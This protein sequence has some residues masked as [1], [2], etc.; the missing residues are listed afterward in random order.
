V[1]ES[2]I[3]PTEPDHARP[4]TRRRRHRVTAVAGVAVG[5]AL[6]VGAAT[7]SGTPSAVLYDS[8]QSNAWRLAPAETVGEQQP[9]NAG[10]ERDRRG[11][12]ERGVVESDS[13]DAQRGRNGSAAD[14]G[15]TARVIS[16]EKPA[17]VSIPS[18]GVQASVIPVGLDDGGGVFVPEDVRTLGWYTESVPVAADQ[19]S[20]VIVGHRDS[21]V[22]GAGAFSGIENLAEGEV[23]EVA[24]TSGDVE[25]YVV[26][27]VKVVLKSDFTSIVEE[28][29]AI[30]G[31]HRLTLITCGGAFD[32]SARSYVSNVFVIA[33]PSTA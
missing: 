17:S 22:Q 5:I 32:S 7:T 9:R 31:E 2:S 1:A 24:T 27:E 3:D 21:A 6:I 26:D 33:T 19:G 11:A 16:G 28:A 4:T 10:L 14:R 18:M 25:T 20:A 15:E 29:F 13:P 12:G 30:N 8:W 23:I